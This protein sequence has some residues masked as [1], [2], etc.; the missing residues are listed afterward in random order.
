MNITAT[1]L[2]GR[3]H[4]TGGRLH[5]R[6]TAEKDRALVAHDDGFVAHRRHV[7]ATG[8]ARAH[9]DGD[10]R[11][12]RG[13]HVGLVEE[14][15]AEVL[16]V[17]KHFV[18]AG[19]VRAA[20]IHEVD[21]GQPV[22]FGDALRAQVLL[23]GHRIVGAALHRG[24]VADDDAFAAGDAPDAGDDAGARRFIA[25]HAE[26]RERREL[27]KRRARIEQH[28]HPVAGQQFSARH[29]F[30]T[31]RLAAAGADF[32]LAG[33][34][35]ADQRPHGRLVGGELGAFPVDFGI[36]RRHDCRTIVQPHI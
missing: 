3:D 31:R 8:R 35:F 4:L 22:L 15:A 16:G 27:E 1:E 7:R 11:N 30:G 17:G 28:F 6:R 29:V 13:R 9:D 23:D 32:R 21:A 33:A 14:D 18:L 25:V 12:G 10:L 26:G 20:R 34:Q 5:Q 24:V 2:L 19:Q 36:Q